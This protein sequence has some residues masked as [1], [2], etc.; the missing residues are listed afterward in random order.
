M[1]SKLLIV[2]R[3]VPD[4]L[5]DSNSLVLNKL[6]K[7]FP[8]GSYNFLIPRSLKI[9]EN[10]QVFT[11][12]DKSTNP[13]FKSHYGKYL[14]SLYNLVSR[15][16]YLYRHYQFSSIL[17]ISSSGIYNICA[18][19][20]RNV[21]R[22]PYSVYFFDVWVGNKL[23]FWN[24]VLSK[25]LES[26]IVK[27]A[28][29]IITCGGGIADLY[30]KKYHIVPII[31]NNPYSDIT[32]Q[33][34]ENTRSLHSK[35]QNDKIRI[36]Y[37]GSIGWPQ[38]DSINTLCMAIKDNLNINF[39]IYTGTSMENIRESVL[40]IDEYNNVKMHKHLQLKDVLYKISKSDIAFLP[41][42]IINDQR[43]SL[44]IKVSEPGKLADYLISG[45]PILIHAPADSYISNYAKKYDFAYVNNDKN[46]ESLLKMIEYIKNHPEE[47]KEKVENALRIAKEFHN[48]QINAIKLKNI[49]LNDK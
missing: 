47:S 14:F 24:D 27:Q 15:I 21:Y 33:I 43:T 48:P 5:V 25:I 3:N 42:Y 31:I 41:L 36:I 8:K 26:S 20:I 49:L 45:T 9:S 46:P 22:I 29:F 34:M 11:Y 6:L 30:A 44:V 23:R 19:I 2:S 17:I 1:K 18:F 37:T 32:M 40:L 16:H 35:H 28:K 7:Y 39:D 4:N 13:F 12:N 10:A 38:K